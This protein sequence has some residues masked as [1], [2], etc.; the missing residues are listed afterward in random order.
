MRVKMLTKLLTKPNL[1][2]AQRPIFLLSHMRSNS[3]LISNLIGNHPQI[4]GYYEMQQAYLDRFD[5]LYQKILFA[6]QHSEKKE[7]NYIF[8]KILHNHLYLNPNL[9]VKKNAIIFISLREPNLTIPSIVKYFSNTTRKKEWG[10]IELATKY[11]CNRIKHLAEYSEK[12][13][14][15]YYYFDASL[16]RNDS[17]ATL[18][19]ISENI[20]LKSSLTN[21]YIPQKLTGSGGAGDRSENI[22]TGNIIPQTSTE[23][24]L[25]L[26][27]NEMTMYYAAREQLIKNANKYIQN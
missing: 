17:Q 22:L 11:Y 1:L 4:N 26:F 21:Q 27:K 6:N 18:T 9:V 16:I 25:K 7:A 12:I 20:G 3:S 5:Y 2:K 24:N 10:N 13:K 19:F 8:D 14:N 23:E 15:K